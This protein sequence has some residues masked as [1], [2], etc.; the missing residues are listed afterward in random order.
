MPSP[1][2][3]DFRGTGKLDLICGSFLDGFTWFENVGTPPNRG[4]R[5]VA[6]FPPG[7]FR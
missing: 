1:C 6:L 7:A 4:M 3:A 5:P 2:F